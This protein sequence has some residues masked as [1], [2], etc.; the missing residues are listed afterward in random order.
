LAHY[1]IVLIETDRRRVERVTAY[2]FHIGIV[3]AIVLFVLD[4]AFG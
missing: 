1:A 2:G 3:A 4:H